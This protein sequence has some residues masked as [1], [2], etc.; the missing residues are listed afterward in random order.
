MKVFISHHELYYY[1]YYYYLVTTTTQAR[2]SYTKLSPIFFCP[3]NKKVCFV[4]AILLRAK[5]RLTLAG[6][7]LLFSMSLPWTCLHEHMHTPTH[8]HTH[9]HHYHHH[10]H[11]NN[12]HDHHHNHNHKHGHQK[13]LSGI[14]GQ[15]R[16]QQH[17]RNAENNLYSTKPFWH[18]GPMSMPRPRAP[19]RLRPTPRPRSGLGS[20]P[21]AEPMP[22]SL[23]GIGGESAQESANGNNNIV[24]EIGGKID[25]GKLAKNRQKNRRGRNRRGHRLGNRW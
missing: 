24:G 14:L 22:R 20:E 21:R 15:G 17:G 5:W 25:G 13:R 7:R 8:T 18:P 16:C 1:C 11:N 12:Y 2:T 10:H 4:G 23:S 19:A 6:V 9:T 3:L